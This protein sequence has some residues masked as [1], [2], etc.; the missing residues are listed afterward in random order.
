[1][2]AV[3]VRI[4][5][6]CE[7]FET[8]NLHAVAIVDPVAPSGGLSDHR[9]VS[10][11]DIA[12]SGEEHDARQGVRHVVD[13][14]VFPSRPALI[15]LFLDVAPAVAVD[16]AAACDG[17]ASRLVR[18]NERG[19]ACARQVFLDDMLRVGPVREVCNIR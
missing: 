6:V 7:D 10:Y 19:V 2:N 3:V 11:D 13:S 18:K 5:D 12:A 16:R 15:L 8:G 9:D 14:L 1:M 17:D 4:A